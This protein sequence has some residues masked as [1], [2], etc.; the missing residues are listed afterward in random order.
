MIFDL[1][2]SWQKPL[3]PELDKPYFSVLNDFV[4]QEYAKHVCYPKKEAIFAAFDFCNFQD[5]K[6]VILGQDPYHGPG[7]ANGLCFSVN[8]GVGHPPSLMNIFKEM[9]ADLGKR[10]PLSG[11][12]E[13][14]AKQG[15]LLLN[16]T[17]TVREREAASHQKQGWET[18]TDAVIEKVSQE[19][20]GIVF[21]L[22]G[23]FAKKK[24]KLIDAKKHHILTSGHP[25]P[26]SANRGYWFGNKHFSM[27][28]EIL[29]KA[30]RPLISW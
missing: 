18:F 19:K 1:H 8:E 11:N 26:L 24:A 9:E 4:K 5:T 14:W 22:W 12:L 2:P 16:A 3:Q 6:V 21:L 27:T 15:V 23:G 7:Q 29:K 25:S 28:N 20:E 30:N 17:L 10:Y 13:A